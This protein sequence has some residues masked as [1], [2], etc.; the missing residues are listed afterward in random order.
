MKDLMCFI[1]IIL[2]VVFGVLL[3]IALVR[4][5]IATIRLSFVALFLA[6]STVIGYNE[7]D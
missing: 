3:I 5:D 6:I 1:W 2:T 4:G 7:E